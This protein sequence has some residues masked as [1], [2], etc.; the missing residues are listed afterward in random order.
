M[1]T[2]RIEGQV[3]AL[4]AYAVYFEVATL[5][6]ARLLQRWNLQIQP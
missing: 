4:K 1:S 5:K 6:L 3:S 2:E